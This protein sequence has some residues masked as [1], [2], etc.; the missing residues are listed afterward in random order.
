MFKLQLLIIMLH[1][2][3][4]K[5]DDKPNTDKRV[6]NMRELFQPQNALLISLFQTVSFIKHL[7]RLLL[8]SLI[9]ID[10]LVPPEKN[11]QLYHNVS[12]LIT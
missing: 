8:L 10:Q 2:Y 4:P 3:S 6:D 12:C 9:N 7:Q 5:H 11:T 1:S